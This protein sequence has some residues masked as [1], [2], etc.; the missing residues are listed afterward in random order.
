MWRLII[1]ALG[2]F[3]F[4]AFLNCKRVTAKK[5][6]GTY[7]GTVREYNAIP[8][9]LPTDNIQAGSFVIS[10]DGKMV[11]SC[12][13]SIHEDSLADGFYN[14][15]NPTGQGGFNSIQVRQDC[16]IVIN[17]SKHKFGYIQF[18]EYRGIKED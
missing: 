4:C 1:F 6:S 5:L 10:K 7:F 16:V 12:G 17:Y 9:S 14:Y 3:A 15:S 2:L 18:S 13:V 8:Y 11:N